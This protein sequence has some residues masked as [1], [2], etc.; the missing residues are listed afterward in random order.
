MLT[1]VDFLEA[2]RTSIGSVL[3]T[4]PWRDLSS[5]QRQA[6]AFIPSRQPRNGRAG[7]RGLF[8]LAQG[9][10]CMAVRQDDDTGTHRYN[11]P[12]FFGAA[13]KRTEDPRS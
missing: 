9:R 6:G 10:N 12:K 13:V 3:A 2:G 1:F 11:R 8:T 4:V 5:L 7:R